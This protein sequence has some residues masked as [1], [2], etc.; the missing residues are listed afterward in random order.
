MSDLK[1]RFEIGQKVLHSRSERVLQV[2]KRKFNHAVKTQAIMVGTNGACYVE[3][4][5]LPDYWSY[6]LSDGKAY[7]Y[8][9]EVLAEVE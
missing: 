9:E 1:P 8:W 2:L 3:D 5:T 4:V 6:K 7:W